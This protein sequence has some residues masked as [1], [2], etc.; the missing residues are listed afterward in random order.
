MQKMVLLTLCLFGYTHGM[1][2]AS[3]NEA[4]KPLNT[5]DCA[6][7]SRE[8]R[9]NFAQEIVVTH[10]G[11]RQLL[12]STWLPLFAAVACQLPLAIND[13]SERSTVLRN[14][15]AQIT[16]ASYF[17]YG[18]LTEGPLTCL[19]NS[20]PYASDD[21]DVEEESEEPTLDD[22]LKNES[23]FNTFS[24]RLRAVFAVAT[25]V[26]AAAVVGTLSTNDTMEDLES[27]YLAQG[28]AY[29]L[30]GLTIAGA[31]RTAFGYWNA[32]QKL[33]DVS[34]RIQKAIDKAINK[35]AGANSTL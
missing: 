7:F 2:R 4:Y 21:E 26:V 9:R 8:K 27:K 29:A 30:A 16:L 10:Y 3:G 32:Y 35:A 31:G 22:L 23:D 25:P 1:V 20:D 24:T 13:D 33:A 28:S 18:L 12:A 6:V 5:H 11:Y 19:S 17:A 34:A 14:V 15:G